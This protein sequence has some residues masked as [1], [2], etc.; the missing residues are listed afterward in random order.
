VDPEVLAIGGLAGDPD[1]L[2]ALD[3]QDRRTHV[4]ARQ[5]IARGNAGSGR[6]AT[7]ESAARAR[8][9]EDPDDQAAADDRA[10]GQRS[11]HR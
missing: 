1:V 4:R 11:T 6:T 8:T 3:R 7:A 9:D 5:D 2:A 10:G